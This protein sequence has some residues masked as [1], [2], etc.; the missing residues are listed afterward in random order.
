M[1]AAPVLINWFV[2]RLHTEPRDTSSLKL[3]LYGASPIP[4]SVLRD[5]MEIMPNTGFQHLYG[6]TEAGGTVVQMAPSEHDPGNPERLKSC[7]QPR[8]N[9]DLRIENESGEVQ[10]VGA[11]GEVMIRGPV[12]MSE[13]WRKPEATAAVFREGWYRTGDAGYLDEDGFLYIVDRV[14]DMIITGGENVYPA[15]VENAL[16]EHNAVAMAAVIGLPDSNWGEAVTA[17]IQRQP[18]A[19]LTETELRQ[20]LRS[21]IA[22]YKIPKRIEFVEEMPLTPSNKIRKHILRERF[23]TREVS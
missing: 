8:F 14:K 20:F 18:D 5:A 10:P 22:G 1:F 21:M 12:L 11:V 3:M 19:T 23:T 4:P 17:F 13:Y 7:G 2:Q 9:I 6:M 16:Y 15:E